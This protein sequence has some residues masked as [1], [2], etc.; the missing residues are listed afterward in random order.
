MG[1]GHVRM[2]AARTDCDLVA[3]C[4]VDRLRLEK[5]AQSVTEAGRGVPETFSDMRDCFRSP[6]IDA[7]FIA[8]P[9]H[10]HAPAAL[11]A[12]EAG[13]HVYVEKPC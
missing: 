12:L 1:G 10:W 5:A 11:L 7:V 2:L 6:N 3:V 4:D 9:D 8:T 13:K